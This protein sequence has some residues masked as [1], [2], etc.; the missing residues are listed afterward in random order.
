MDALYDLIRNLVIILLLA[1]FLEMLL[2]SKSLKGFVKLTMGLFV[3]S[4]I[5]TPLTSFLGMTMESG[6]PAWI[7]NVDEGLPVLASG[8][9]GESMGTN[10]VLDQYKVIISNQVKALTVG[11]DDVE[12]D[13]EVKLA[14]GT[15]SITNP[16]Q[17]EEIRIHLYEKSTGIKPVEKIII[18]RDSYIEEKESTLSGTALEI[19]N[20]VGAFLQIPQEKIIIKEVNS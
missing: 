11:M 16:P 4:A 10:A 17:I 19:R 12:L 15:G 1:G 2:P 7:E 13:V 14:E 5:L 8:E 3:I 20:K 18:N 9:E 6:I